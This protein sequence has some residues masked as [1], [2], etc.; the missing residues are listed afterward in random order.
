[1]LAAFRIKVNLMQNS[2]LSF[3]ICIDHTEKLQALIDQLA[4]D[5]YVR[6]NNNVELYTIR[7]YTSEAIEKLS[8]DKEI[9]LE[10]RSRNTLQ[11]IVRK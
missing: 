7:H 6:Y 9:I 5:F 2:A 10:Q 8:K 11:L 3:S 1:V 4:H